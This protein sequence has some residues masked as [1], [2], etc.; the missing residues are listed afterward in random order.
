MSL[1]SETFEVL[2]GMHWGIVPQKIK[3]S[4]DS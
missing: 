3:P 1:L 2:S 4:Y